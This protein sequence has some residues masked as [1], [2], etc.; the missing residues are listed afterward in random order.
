M[1]SRDVPTRSPRPRKEPHA[2][3]NQG[4]HA[5]HADDRNRGALPAFAAHDERRYPAA[6]HGPLR[7]TVEHV[8]DASSQPAIGSDLDVASGSLRNGH[9]A[10]DDVGERDRRAVRGPCQR[11]AG[12]HRLQRRG[13]V[14][15]RRGGGLG[16]LHEEA[17]V[18]AGAAQPARS[19]LPLDLLDGSLGMQLQH[20]VLDRT[21]TD[22][23][24]HVR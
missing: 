17:A 15:G 6:G 9:T 4:D 24:R 14:R 20:R 21:E 10:P 18:A 2:R 12:P 7:Q 5:D 3:S 1:L 19:E 8:V 23:A 13:L 22:T 11:I 16:C